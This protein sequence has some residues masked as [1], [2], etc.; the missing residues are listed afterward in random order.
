ML[1]G[2]AHCSGGPGPSTFDPLTALE[3]W[4]EEGV[5]PT[6]LIA[7][8]DLGD[9]RTRTR[10]LCVYPEVAHWNGEGDTDD[11]ASFVI[12]YDRT[13]PGHAPSH[14]QANYLYWMRGRAVR[15]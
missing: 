7:S 9:G 11:E 3:E 10:P 5:A 15:C 1:P 12:F 6:R 2:M 4:V 14:G 13:A 8:K